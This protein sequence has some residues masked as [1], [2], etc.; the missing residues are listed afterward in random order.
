M[1]K[2]IYGKIGRS[3]I[4]DELK[5]GPVGGD[6]EPLA[7]LLK[8]ANRHPDTEFV[9]GCRWSG[10]KA[11]RER[12]PKNITLPNIPKVT[13]RNTYKNGERIFDPSQRPWVGF[14]DELAPHFVEA[15]GVIMWAGQMGTSNVP[16]PR[17]E[18]ISDMTNP[19]DA[20]MTYVGP[21]TLN[22]NMWRN[23]DESRREVW[24]CADPRNYMKARDLKWPVP[25]VLAQ[26]IET[27]QQKHYRWGDWRQPHELGYHATWDDSTPNSN[28]WVVNHEYLYSQ[29]EIVG[30]PDDWND[31]L[32]LD[33]GERQG[34]GI[35]INEARSYVGLDRKS[36][37]RDWVM[38]W[39]DADNIRGKWSAKSM[40]ELGI[41]PEP[42]LH[43]TI[44]D[45]LSRF[46]ATF[47]TPSS[48]SGWATTKWWEAAAL[49]TVCFCHPN[50]DD[51]GHVVPTLAAVEAGVLDDDPA[52]KH[53]TSW[54]RPSTPQELYERVKAVCSS[55]GTYEWLRDQQY[56]LYRRAIAE[57]RAIK[58]I[59]ERVP[60]W[61]ASS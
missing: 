57:Q 1:H 33:F 37:M 27:H 26:H 9:V 22:I 17:V 60:A 5:Y 55:Q 7:L 52:L 11:A 14:A 6:N 38:P 3:M 8:L 34:F 48:G 50:W 41:S 49:G 61:S 45:F 56:K 10:D 47:T 59:E 43:K 42:I 58:M 25:P 24:L 23:V 54:L 53:L 40:E 19:Q 13:P 31:D 15:G 12:L 39:V 51:Q 2:V 44:P 30:I 28:V 21:I 36:I 35:L 16:I 4:L 20:F 32:W 46:H 29:L 18:D